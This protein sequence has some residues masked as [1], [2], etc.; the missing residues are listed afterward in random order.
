MNIAVYCSARPGLP[1]EVTAD[2]R[3]LGKWI[4]ENGHILVYGGLANGLMDEVAATAARAGAKVIGVVPHSRVNR[5]HP[6]N[7]VNISVNSLHERKEIMEENADLFVALDGG[8]GTL[9]E[10]MSALATMT[11]FDDP[12]PIHLLNR[13][14]LYDPLR[15]MLREMANRRLASP[16][17]V[18][19]LQLHPDIESLI[20]AIEQ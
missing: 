20:K 9:D 14:G 12:K 6:D 2:A 4:G 5:Q 16:E 1:D 19:R 11:F 3:R 10:V 17:V 15:A 13:R 8:F 7:T 18:E